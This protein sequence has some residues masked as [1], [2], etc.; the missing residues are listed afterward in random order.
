ME[1]IK[2]NGLTDSVTPLTP[3]SFNLDGGAETG[4]II[5]WVFIVIALTVSIGLGIWWFTSRSETFEEN[6]SEEEC[7]GRVVTITP[8]AFTGLK[9]KKV[10]IPAPKVVN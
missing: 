5:M 7:E 4:K 8:P 6:V 3:F 1:Y 2:I 9:P 10:C